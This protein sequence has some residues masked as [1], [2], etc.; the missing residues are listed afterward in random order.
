MKNPLVQKQKLSTGRRFLEL[1][2]NYLRSVS[3]IVHFIRKEEKE[4]LKMQNFVL[5]NLEIRSGLDKSQKKF[6]ET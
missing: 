2:K 6:E 4:M 5:V 3:V 1:F